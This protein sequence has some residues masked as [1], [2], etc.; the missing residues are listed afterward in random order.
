MAFQHYK[1]LLE[2]G[3][4]SSNPAENW[5]WVVQSHLESYNS[6]TEHRIDRSKFESNIRLFQYDL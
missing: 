4:N 5:K 3:G 6:T 2:V 1:N